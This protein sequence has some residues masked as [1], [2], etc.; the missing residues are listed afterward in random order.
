MER[1]KCLFCEKTLETRNPKAKY[2]SDICRVRAYRKHYHIPEP[3]A[4]V[5]EK[6]AEIH[7]YFLNLPELRCCDKPAYYHPAESDREI[8]CKNC[9]A[10]FEIFISIHK[11]IQKL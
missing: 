10:R 4:P 9:Y 7:S 6:S 5:S 8:R 3:F 1:R 2:C 11:I